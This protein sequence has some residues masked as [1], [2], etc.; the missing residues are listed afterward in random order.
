LWS[1]AGGFTD[2]QRRLFQAQL[3][4]FYARFVSKVAAGRQMSFDAVDAVARGRVWS[5]AQ[6]L[7]HGLVDGIGGLD[8]ALD[9]AR[10]MVGAEPGELLRVRTYGKELGWL[11][12]AMLDALRSSQVASILEPSAPLAGVPEPLATMAR[13]LLESGLVDVA[14]LLDGRP[15]AL[16]PWR[17]VAQPGGVTP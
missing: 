11:E 3:D 7:E 14:P 12:R 5:G 10:A 2:N 4:R 9:S 8:R 17:P 13:R 16:M 15:V 1:D 6:A